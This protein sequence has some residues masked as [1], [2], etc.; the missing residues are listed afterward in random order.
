GDDLLK[1]V[2]RRLDLA[3]VSY[4]TVARL[5][6]DEFA[7]LISEKTG[8][9]WQ[10]EPI[11]KIF[12]AMKEPIL[13]NDTRHLCTLS[14]GLTVFPDEAKTASDL[15]KNADLALYCAKER[16]RDRVQHYAPRMRVALEKSYR[17]QQDLRAAIVS[18]AL[19]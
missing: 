4:G 8:P 6:G 12:A 13:L 2:A 15:L 9:N 18:N 17:L 11:Q 1:E 16:G 5:G 7:F 14:L 10:S 3:L 19:C